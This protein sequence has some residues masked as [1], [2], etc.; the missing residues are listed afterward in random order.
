MD[1]QEWLKELIYILLT[2][3]FSGTILVLHLAPHIEHKMNYVHLLS[4]L[5]QLK[6]PF[7]FI[8]HK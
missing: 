7:N 1:F 5:L 6:F 2:V 3:P 4:F 8:I